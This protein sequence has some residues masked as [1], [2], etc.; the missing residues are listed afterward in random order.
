MAAEREGQQH[1]DKT[2]ADK[3]ITLAVRYGTAWWLPVLLLAVSVANSLTSGTLVWCLGVTQAVLY[4]VVVLSYE[5]LRFLQAP[6]ALTI[7][8]SVAAYSYLQ[9][10][11]SEGVDDF[12]A[13][14]G[15]NDSAWLTTTQEWAT[16]YGAAGL[17]LLQVS[18][19]PIPT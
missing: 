1:V 2:Y 18:P 11:H 8:S 3:L 4:A 16:S 19:I 15:A 17:F 6:F 14:S 13:T 9:L 12:L 7:G 5:D 10:M